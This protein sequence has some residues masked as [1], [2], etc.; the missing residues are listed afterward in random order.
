MSW[1]IELTNKLIELYPNTE[2]LEISIILNISKKSIESKANRLGLKKS[3]RL[4][5][6]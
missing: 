1:S 5:H 6:I 2:N 4:N 3:R